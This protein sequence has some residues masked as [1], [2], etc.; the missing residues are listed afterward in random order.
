MHITK[1]KLKY[2]KAVT[3]LLTLY[4]YKPETF[5][6]ALFQYVTIYC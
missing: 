6:L 5:F 2:P 1:R 4:V 3:F